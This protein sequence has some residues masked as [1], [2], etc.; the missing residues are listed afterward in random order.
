MALGLLPTLAEHILQGMDVEE[1]TKEL[2]SRSRAP[3]VPSPSPPPSLPAPPPDPPFSESTSH[4]SRNGSQEHSEDSAIAGSSPSII[5]YPSHPDG[6]SSEGPNTS[7]LTSADLT[8]STSSWVKEFESR[9]GVSSDVPSS[10]ASTSAN[11]DL[12]AVSIPPTL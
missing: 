8:Q 5:S 9:T 3:P 7:R 4:G 11:E 10:N 12:S 1:L 6:Q 2:Q